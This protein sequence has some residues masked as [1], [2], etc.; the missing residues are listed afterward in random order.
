MFP[1]PDGWGISYPLSSLLNYILIIG[2]SLA[3]H[4]LNK[5]F[6]FINSTDT[7]MPSAMLVLCSSNLLLDQYLNQSLLLGSAMVLVLGILMGCYRNRRSMA[8]LFLCATILSITAMFNYCALLFACGLILMALA[9]QCLN[10]RGFVAIIMG[11]L[12][13]WWILFGFGIVNFEDFHFPRINTIFQFVGCGNANFMEW[14]NY[15]VTSLIFLMCSLYNAVGLYA[16]NTKR[17][18]LCN[19]FMLMG[20]IS[21]AGIM[22]DARN[23]SSYMVCFYI[24][25]AVQLTNLFVLHNLKN[26]RGVLCFF[27][28][29]YC[30]MYIAMINGL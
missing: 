10:F 29:L 3:L 26:V 23:A 16:G 30:A 5:N 22:I 15:G 2:I 8:E 28:I 7:V 17:R 14:I 12:A 24:S 18:V 11:V 20:F 27:L 21:I 9:M 19:T 4:L 6:N 13:P 25:T 1:G